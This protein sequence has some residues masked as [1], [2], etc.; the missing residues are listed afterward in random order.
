M[1]ISSLFYYIGTAGSSAIRN[2]TTMRNG[3]GASA[4]NQRKLSIVNKDGKTIA[5]T[6]RVKNRPLEAEIIGED[7]T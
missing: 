5:N 1:K 3:R 4:R 6:L 2:F 7:D